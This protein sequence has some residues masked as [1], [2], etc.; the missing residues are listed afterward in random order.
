MAIFS[1]NAINAQGL[2]SNGIIHAPDLTNAREQLQARGLLPQSLREKA[3]AGEQSARTA[4][5]RSSRS[6]CR[7][8]RASSRR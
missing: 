2:E 5:R 7:S 4:S 6:R 8:S 1:Y 3:A